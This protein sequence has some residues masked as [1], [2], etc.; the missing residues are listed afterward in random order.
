MKFADFPKPFD[1]F[2]TVHK[3]TPEFLMVPDPN[4][5]NYSDLYSIRVRAVGS[6]ANAKKHAR[7][8]AKTHNLEPAERA[9][10]KYSPLCDKWTV[11]ECNWEMYA[12]RW[13]K[14]Q[15]GTLVFLDINRV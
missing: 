7:E 15:D 10:R 14:T 1:A 6:M 12:A 8:L 13:Y 4:P 11:E 2:I 9:W 3:T 5:A